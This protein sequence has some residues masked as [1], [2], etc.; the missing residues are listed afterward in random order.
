MLDNASM[1]A[2]FKVS[3]VKTAKKNT[4]DFIEKYCSSWMMG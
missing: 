3:D 4:D 1:Y 2:I